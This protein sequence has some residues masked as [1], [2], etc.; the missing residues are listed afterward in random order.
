MCL[1][2]VYSSTF[3]PP[4][5]SV[6]FFVRWLPF[7]SIEIDSSIEAYSGGLDLCV[8]CSPCACAVNGVCVCVCVFVFFNPFMSPCRLL[9]SILG[10]TCSPF[11]SLSLSLSISLSLCSICSVAALTAA[12]IFGHPFHYIEFAF[13]R[14]EVL[15]FF[16]FLF[17]SLIWRYFNSSFSLSLMLL[18][19]CNFKMFE[20]CFSTTA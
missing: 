4:F 18:T 7:F 20:V 12:F 2:Q 9:H 16:S 10:H 8:Y 1:S 17:A 19:V 11:L 15:E 6:P 13:V 5:A 3:T 14:L